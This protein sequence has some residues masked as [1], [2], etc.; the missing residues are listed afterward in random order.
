MTPNRVSHTDNLRAL[1]RIV[2]VP[3]KRIVCEPS[4]LRTADKD[5]QDTRH[6]LNSRQHL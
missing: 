1:I 4:D 2:V 3:R 5:E 6:S